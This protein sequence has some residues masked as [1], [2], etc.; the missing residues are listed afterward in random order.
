MPDETQ[1]RA[2]LPGPQVATIPLLPGSQGQRPSTHLSKYCN[3]P[4]W[5]HQ[6]EAMAKDFRGSSGS[7]S[8]ASRTAEM[9][10]LGCYLIHPHLIPEFPPQWLRQG[11]PQFLLEYFQR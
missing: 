2:W 1:G 6:A 11:L 3:Y 7:I 5:V 4:K 9:G 8:R 10:V